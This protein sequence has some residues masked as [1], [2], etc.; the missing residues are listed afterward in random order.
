MA[1]TDLA[2]AK[3]KPNNPLLR[4]NK[5][6]YLKLRK[7]RTGPACPRALWRRAPQNGIESSSSM[8]DDGCGCSGSSRSICFTWLH[9]LDVGDGGTAVDEMHDR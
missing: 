8:S 3:F 4:S 6:L 7:D 9:A 5:P 2:R 1:I